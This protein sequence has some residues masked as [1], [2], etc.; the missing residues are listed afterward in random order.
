MPQPLPMDEAKHPTPPGSAARIRAS[1]QRDAHGLPVHTLS[2]H[3]P[4]AQQ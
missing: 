3:F 4:I 1:L 2:Q